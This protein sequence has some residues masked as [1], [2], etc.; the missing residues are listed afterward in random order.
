MKKVL[1]RGF[2]VI[3]GLSAIFLAL[4]VINDHYPWR[5]GQDA[6]IGSPKEGAPFS[7]SISD[8]VA[9]QD[10]RSDYYTK[11]V[12]FAF[13]MGMLGALVLITITGMYRRWRAGRQ[14]RIIESIKPIYKQ[15][16]PKI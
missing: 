11:D 13:W 9:K 15:R 1:F 6:E 16:S 4:C 12:P 8:W 10:V 5:T 3:L 14:R 7:Q 2:L